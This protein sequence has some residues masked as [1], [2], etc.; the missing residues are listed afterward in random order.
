MEET[1]DKQHQQQQGGLTATG[2]SSVDSMTTSTTSTKRRASGIHSGAA[3]ASGSS[4]K[5]PGGTV[6]SGGGDQIRAHGVAGGS[7]EEAAGLRKLFVCDVSDVPFPHCP[8]LPVFHH[9]SIDRDASNIHAS[10]RRTTCITYVSG[11]LSRYCS[12]TVVNHGP[13]QTPAELLLLESARPP[14]LLQGQPRHL[15]GR[16][17]R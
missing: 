2:G 15:G 12:K 6:P 7:A 11:S 10:L 16:W 8:L 9:R 13:T 17:R 5:I 1:H 4:T 3:P 14:S